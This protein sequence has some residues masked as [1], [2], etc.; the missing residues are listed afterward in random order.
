MMTDD[1][2][3]ARLAQRMLTA[4]S[5][6]GRM[7]LRLYMNWKRFAWR[8]TIGITALVKRCIDI[9]ASGV[10]LL[11][12]S[13]LMIV[14]ALLVRRDG[15]PVFFKQIRVGLRGKHFGMLKFRSMCVDA[16]AKLKE[17]LSQNEKGDGI[18]FKMKNDPRITPMSQ[19]RT[20]ETTHE[21]G[22]PFRADHHGRRRTV[23]TRLRRAQ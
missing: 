15:G 10:L 17:L 1:Q 14:I 6:A 8:W 23:R 13:P 16:E 4:S 20:G 21:Q 9:A 11:V 12:L 5:P 18:T 7:R 22:S 3:S 19:Q 2:L